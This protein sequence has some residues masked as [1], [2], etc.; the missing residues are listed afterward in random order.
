MNTAQPI[1]IT[2]PNL[3]SMFGTTTE[4]TQGS[5]QNIEFGMFE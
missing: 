2:L 4:A 3:E 5:S 1:V